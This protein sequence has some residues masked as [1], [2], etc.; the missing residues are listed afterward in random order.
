[1]QRRSESII[2]PVLLW[3]ALQI[4]TLFLSANRVQLWARMS[5]PTENYALQ[6]MLSEQIAFAAMLFPWLLRT[7]RS[8]AF[9]FLSSA[10]FLQLAGT[11]GSDVGSDI[12]LAI[13]QI[14]MWL[15]ILT[16]W[17]IVLATPRMQMLGVAIATSLAIGGFSI[18]YLQI[19]FTDGHLPTN[20]IYIAETTLAVIG[21]MMA[22]IL[23]TRR[24]R[25][26]T[27]Y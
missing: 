5:K 27:N 21:A 11:L 8:T 4:I 26:S 15:I 6:I 1:M 3:S 25:L 10:L 9:V 22:V 13:S 12:V 16:L 2:A 24:D 18:Y 14:W 7:A 23:V 20:V 17:R 19:E